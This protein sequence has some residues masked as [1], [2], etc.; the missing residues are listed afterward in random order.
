[1]SDKIHN[2]RIEFDDETYN[3]LE[4]QRKQLKKGTK[5]EYLR[6]LINKR[7]SLKKLS[8]IH[9]TIRINEALFR[10]I[11]QMGNN[12]N[13]IAHRVNEDSR[14]YNEEKFLEKIEE[15]LKATNELKVLLKDTN[16]ELKKVI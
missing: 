7:A 16:K 11:S 4:K 14:A 5:A 10:H 15:V 9:Q 1:M 6:D 12:I 3:N 2:Y 8:N 13:Q